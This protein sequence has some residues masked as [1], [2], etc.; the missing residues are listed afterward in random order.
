MSQN[1]LAEQ[2][3]GVARAVAV[4]TATLDR[5][6]LIDGRAVAQTLRLDHTGAK[7]ADEMTT[8]IADLI[9][10]IIERTEAGGPARLREVDD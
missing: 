4:L 6:G 2:I 10:R 1:E 8:E 7:R 5:A 9:R 3:G